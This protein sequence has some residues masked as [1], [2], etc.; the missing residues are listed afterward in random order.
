MRNAD[1]RYDI[2]TWAFM[3]LGWWVSHLAAVAVIGY[4]GY[5]LRKMVRD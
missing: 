3:G 4:I 2:G 1:E 5:Y